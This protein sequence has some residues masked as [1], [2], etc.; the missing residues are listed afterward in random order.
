MTALL[1]RSEPPGLRAIL[2]LDRTNRH[3][4]GGPAG[5]VR[6]DD[7]ALYALAAALAA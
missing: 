2:A 5:C 4:C 6:G 7:W 1:N 3:G